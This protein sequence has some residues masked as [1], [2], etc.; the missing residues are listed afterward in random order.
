MLL[1]QPKGACSALDEP[2][3]IWASL[4]QRLAEPKL[5]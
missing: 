5:W 3:W 2:P 4:Q 1:W